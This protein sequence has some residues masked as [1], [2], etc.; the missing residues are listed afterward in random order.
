M[1]T[2][3]FDYVAKEDIKT[4]IQIDQKLVNTQSNINNWRL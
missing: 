2:F 3:N 4:I 1:K